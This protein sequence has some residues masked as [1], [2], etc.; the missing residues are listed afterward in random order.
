MKAHVA[1]PS[2]NKLGEGPL[3]SVK[4]QSLYWIDIEH[5]SIHQWRPE[6]R[7]YRQWKLP[8]SIGSFAFRQNGGAILAM[9]DGFHTFDFDT[10]VLSPLIDPEAHLPENR[11]NDGK[12][13]PGGCFWAG[14]LHDKEQEARGSLYRL[15]P[16]GSYRMIRPDII[17]SNGLG[18]SPDHQTMYFTDSGTQCIYAYDFDMRN[19]EIS[20]ERVFARD[21]DC[22]P[23][24]LT[25]DSEGYVWSAKWDGWR[26]VRYSPD[27]KIDAIVEMPVQRPTSVMFGG[28]ELNQL[29]ITSAWTRLAQEVK[30]QQP[31]AGHVFVVETEVSGLPETDYKG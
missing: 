26:V 8:S 7:A 27:G 23:D 29:Y 2:A 22:Y 16:D 14:T 31:L 10:Q 13:D 5:P 19:S 25:V 20:N 12:C 6:T 28:P 11:F 21:T 9:R 18:W 24:G 4:D 1:Y 17:V 30:A 3:W 15:D